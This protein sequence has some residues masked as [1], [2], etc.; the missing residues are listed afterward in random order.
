M[1]RFQ[2]MQVFQ[3][4][5]QEQGFSAAARRLNMSPPAVTRAIAALE[6]DLGIKLF[7]RTTRI[8]RA[9]EVGL[10]YLEDVGRILTEVETADEAAAGINA[11]PRGQLAVTAPVL[12][13]RLFVMQ[14]IVEYLSSYPEVEVNALFLDRN[15]GLIEEGIDV[16]IRIGELPDSNLHALRVGSVRVVLVAS[17]DYIERNGLPESPLDLSDRQFI[18]TT[19]GN[20]AMGWRFHFPDGE[21]SVRIK[22]RLQVTANDAAIE[23]ARC[24]FGITRVMSYQV[25]RHLADGSL[26][27]LLADF[28]PA[29]RP[30]HIVHREGRNA[31]TKT[32][33]FI[34]LLAHR[35]RQ[36]KAL[37]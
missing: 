36:D 9:T 28:E 30:I 15:V 14:H 8:V 4:V 20:S 18:A 22:S 35:L 3:A 7:N 32:R 6:D 37:N 5:A 33:A 10:R 26:N 23:A 29:P 1:G 19:A 13:G 12:F 17:P 2:Q 27:I 34:D 25:A 31:S 24:G 11:E 21:R 16:A